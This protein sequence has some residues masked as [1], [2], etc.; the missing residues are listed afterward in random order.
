MTH[1]RRRKVSSISR[2][3]WRLRHTRFLPALMLGGVWLKRA[4]FEIGQ[5]VSIEVHEGRII[6]KQD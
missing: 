4:G 6:I 5:T 1:I 2:A 3:N